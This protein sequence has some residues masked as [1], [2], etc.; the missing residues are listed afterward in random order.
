[1]IRDENDKSQWQTLIGAD[2]E[3]PFWMV[4]NPHGQAP[5]FRHHTAKSAMTE[6]ERLATANPGQRF[7]VLEAKSVCVSTSVRWVAVDPD[8]VPF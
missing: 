2:E 1:M 7:H 4:W 5:T 8:W 6:A 3:A